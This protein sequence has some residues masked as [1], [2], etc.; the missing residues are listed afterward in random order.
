MAK[1][2]PEQIAE[3][4]IEEAARSGATELN[5]SGLKLRELPESIGRLTQLQKF[6]LHTNQLAALPESIGELTQLRDFVLHDNQLTA[7]PE[8]LGR[9]TRL[10]RL[11]LNDNRV[12]ALPESI[13]RLTHLQRLWLHSNQLTALPESIGSLTQLQRLYLHDNQLTALP[14]S[15]GQL[16]QLRVVYLHN[17]QLT[18]LPESM[19]KLTHLE[20]LYL[21]DNDA[22]GIPPEILGPTWQQVIGGVEAANPAEILQYYF[23]SR[24]EATRALNEAKILLVGQ[25]GVGKTSLVK[26]LVENTFDPEEPKTEGINITQWPIPAQ[27]GAADGNIRLNIW[28]FG[29]QEIMHATHQFFLTKRSLY[30]LVLDAREGESKGNMHYWLRIIQSYGA[31]SP[32]LVVINKNEPPNQLD[33]NE[34]RLGKD[35]ASNVR[36]FFKTSC[37]DGTGIAELRAAIEEQVERL[38]HVHDRVPVSYFRV[39]EELEKQAREKDFLDI[40]EYQG[41]CRTHGVKEQSHQRTLIRFLHDLGNVLNF[42]DPDNPYQLRDTKVLNPEW[43][44]GGVYKIL[45]NQMLMRQDGVLERRQLGEVLADSEKY[46]PDREQF[47]LDMMRRFE[48]CSA[49]PDSEGQRF[50]IPELL[51]PNEPELNWEE[52]DALNFQYH[53]TALPVG[54]MPRLIVR[55][56]G[57]LTTNRTT[58]QSG[59][60]L[61]IEGCRALV[62]GDTQAGKVYISVQ[63]EVPARRRN[64]L[65]VIRDQFRQIHATIPK[66]G[67]QEKV[68][69]PDNPHVVVGYEHL[70][71]L[72][73]QGIETYAPEGAKKAYPVQDL[74][75]GIE[76]PEKRRQE[77]ERRG[78]E[79][80]W[81]RG[82]REPGTEDANGIEDPEKRRQERERGS[83]GPE[84]EEAERRGPVDLRTFL[85]VGGF[86][87]LAFVVLS[88]V[89][90]ALTQL[91]GAGATGAIVSGV[92]L[93]TVLL[94]VSIA[95]F[96]GKFGADRAERILGWILEKIPGLRGGGE[97]Q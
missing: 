22:L 48:L 31:D 23:R 49:F 73:E 36:G 45:N 97:S 12:T 93:F 79:G 14:E 64:A 26:R 32:V 57:S 67:A 7:L 11:T 6:Y 21:H 62:R 89:L 19:E 74:L 88:G 59:A 65:A 70:L 37:S 86:V 50:L 55:M 24:A 10:R 2:T 15:I 16:T 42:D 77:R 60:V 38:E 54:I 17:N 52:A 9:L 4:K 39:K 58:W 63:G 5:L 87:L 51:R 25:G 83:R 78:R 66:I 56:H 71:W 76:D 92:A 94:I 68:P 81:E 28:D 43:V 96:T 84:T 95:L 30:L 82:S 40:D 90:G 69:L 20:Q 44:T 3:R 27:S 8:S 35:Y 29:G 61:E 33:L 18:A 91:C 72:E 1:E 46:P 47:I 80:E 13:A 41:L 34:T 85:V 75:N 53:Y